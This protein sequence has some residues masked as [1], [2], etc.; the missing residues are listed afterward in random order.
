MLLHNK[1][2]KKDV[3]KMKVNHSFGD[4]FQTLWIENEEITYGKCNC[5]WGK[6]NED[7][8]SNQEKNICKHLDSAIK[9][10]EL[11]LWNQKKRRTIE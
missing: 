8:F 3:Y 6:F 5:Q 2:N 11:K 10:E 1:R 9:Q 4:Y 7:Q